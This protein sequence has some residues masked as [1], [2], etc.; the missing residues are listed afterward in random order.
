[1]QS[2]EQKR[3]LLSELLTQ[4]EKIGKTNVFK[5][6]SLG[7]P[8]YELAEELED[9]NAMAKAM[10]FMSMGFCYGKK[11]NN[12]A[13]IKKA[14]QM[15]SPSE[16][17][18][19]IRFNNLLGL[20]YM[21]RG[22]YSMAVEY[23]A[24]ALERAEKVN[25]PALLFMIL[26]NLG[27]VFK[28]LN[29]DERALVYYQE[30]YELFQAHNQVIPGRYYTCIL[31]NLVISYCNAKQLDL[32]KNYLDELEEVHLSG[33]TDTT[34]LSFSRG[35]Y[36]EAIGAYDEAILHYDV[37]I[38]AI[39]DLNLVDN[40]MRAYKRLGDCHAGNGDHYKA[41]D[42]YQ[43]ASEWANYGND[44]ASD[45]HCK[46]RIASLYQSMGQGDKA[47]IYYR[48]MCQGHFR[49]SKKHNDMHSDYM[50]HKLKF[51][52]LKQ[53][54]H[55]VDEEHRQMLLGKVSLQRN[56]KRL[57]LAVAIGNGLK[58]IP[59]IESML[60]L[61]NVRMRELMS[62]YC[63][64]LGCY[65]ETQ[66]VLDLV[67]ILE[68]GTIRGDVTISLKR[69][70]SFNMK[71][72]IREGRSVMFGSQEED[73]S[74]R[75]EDYKY[76]EAYDEVQSAMYV[77]IIAENVIKGVLTVQSQNANEYDEN[78]LKLLEIISAYFSQLSFNKK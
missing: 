26:N 11:E 4:A 31:D 7:R 40:R 70:E 39:E 15:I 45:I 59:S 14:L 3:Q 6:E 16:E 1:M 2:M 54:K 52:Q 69:P 17:V 49:Y 66:D 47:L 20:D 64:G 65:D 58:S 76:K 78:D 50:M 62:V 22:C 61:L 8:A 56:Y 73:H 29:D 37:F 57:D 25:E 55:Y 71:T 27:E 72:C 19:I 12:A 77:P 44:E 48:D 60:T 42:A 34:W 9:E 38:K 32:A 75:L 51:R 24:K 63:I 43:M 53:A 18:F 36:C 41:I 67:H 33:D 74:D 13:S 21:V 35:C 10:Y 28:N 30:A 23:Y 68:D 5:A 46:A